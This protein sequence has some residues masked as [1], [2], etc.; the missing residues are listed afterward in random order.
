MRSICLVAAMIASPL[1]A[2]ESQD[3]ITHFELSPLY[4]GRVVTVCVDEEPCVTI[5]RTNDGLAAFDIPRN[6]VA[7]QND[8]GAIPGQGDF[9]TPATIIADTISKSLSGSGKVVVKYSTKETKADGS[10]KETKV[11]VEVSGSLGKTQ[12]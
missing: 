7:A 3:V 12:K 2:S 9:V 8:S 6:D 11:E 10:S 1:S 5:D 4:A